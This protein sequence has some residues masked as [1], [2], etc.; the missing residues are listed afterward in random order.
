M[1]KNIYKEL[2]LKI[3]N[4]LLE[5]PRAEDTLEGIVQWWILKKKIDQR[6]EEVEKA[7]QFLASQGLVVEVKDRGP[8]VLYKMN[9]DRLQDILKLLKKKG[10]K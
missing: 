6:I 8:R 1:S 4:Y 7:I 10:K 9:Q 5:N 2:S 3:L